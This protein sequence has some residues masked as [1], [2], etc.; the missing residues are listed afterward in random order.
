[1]K[2]R[3]KKCIYAASNNA[4]CIA[5]GRKRLAPEAAVLRWALVLLGKPEALLSTPRVPL[6]KAR[7]QTLH[8]PQLSIW[9]THAI[10]N[11]RSLCFPVL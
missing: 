11:N 9:K 8:F 6:P 3:P 10:L 4:F 7:V 2:Q 5:T 1:M